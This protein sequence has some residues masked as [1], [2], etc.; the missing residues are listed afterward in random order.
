MAS[1][2]SLAAPLPAHEAQL[3]VDP[4][5]HVQATDIPSNLP[6]AL[7]RFLADN[8][9]DSGVYAAAN[10]IRRHIRINP[11]RPIGASELKEQVRAALGGRG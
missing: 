10:S 7:S 8:G 6:V 9:L 11:R 2:D 4:H 1:S 5:T 3:P